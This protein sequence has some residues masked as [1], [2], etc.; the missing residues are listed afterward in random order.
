MLRRLIQSWTN[1][2]C[3]VTVLTCQWSNDQLQMEDLDGATIVRVPTGR[4]RF[5]GTLQY[6]HR[7]QQELQRRANSRDLVYI[8]MLKHAAFATLGACQRRLPIVLRAEGAGTTGDVSWQRSAF[9]GNWIASR[10]RGAD[11]IVA[12]SP[13]I[14][15]ELLAAQYPD[16]RLY[17]IPNGVPIPATAWNQ[18]ETVA[19]RRQLHLP[20]APTIVYTGRLHEQKGLTDLIAAIHTLPTTAPPYQLLLV[21]DGPERATLESLATELGIRARVH[22]WGLVDNVE[23]FLRASDLFVLP[24]Y[25]EG[26]SVSLLEA[27]A[28]GLPALASDILP[29]Q[30][31]V[32]RDQLP[33]FPI[34][35]PNMLARALLHPTS[36]AAASEARNSVAARFSIQTV[37]RMHLELFSTLIANRQ[38]SLGL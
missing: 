15:Q 14:Y 34:Q 18:A 10:C 12:P 3:N 33:L 37:A 25:H 17:T 9:F 23:P 29:N 24:S 2:N 1:D 7:L 26:M 27:L 21:G 28:L 31:L 32:A 22:F 11:A 16:T 30:Q 8:S 19:W 38:T 4:W 13:A 5:I 20:E 35:N 36:V 6:I